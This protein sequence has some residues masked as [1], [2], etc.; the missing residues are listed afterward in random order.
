VP[1]LVLGTC[2][3]DHIDVAGHG[4][5]ALAGLRDIHETWMPAYM[6]QP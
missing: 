4:R 2:G 1:A 3:G 5:V 6:A